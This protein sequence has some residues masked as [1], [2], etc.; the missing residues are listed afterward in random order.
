MGERRAFTVALSLMPC[1]S[2][3]H[4]ASECYEDDEIADTN[5]IGLNVRQT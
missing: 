2:Y 3:V 5:S 4:V 1:V